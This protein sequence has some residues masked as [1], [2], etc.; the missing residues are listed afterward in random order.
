MGGGKH[1]VILD[2]SKF[3]ANRKK[4]PRYRRRQAGP[5]NLQS[6]R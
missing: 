4:N 5:K 2:D 1:V 3:E 6:A